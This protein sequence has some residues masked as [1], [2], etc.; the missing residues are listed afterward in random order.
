MKGPD[1]RGLEQKEEKAHQTLGMAYQQKGMMEEALAEFKSAVSLSG[2]SPTSV[3]GLASAYAAAGQPR[4]AQRE[5]AH[6]EEISQHHYVP[7]FYIASVHLALGDNVKTF[8]W[9]WKA[10]DERS[11]YFLY[12]RVEPRAGKLAANPEFIRLLAHLHP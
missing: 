10:L 6:L 12:L 9:A 8:Q 11:D 1:E 4:L 5:L 2:N 7:A 3:A